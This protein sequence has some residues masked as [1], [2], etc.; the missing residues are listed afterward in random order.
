MTV[1]KMITLDDAFSGTVS[2]DN[3]VSEL[4]T[5]GKTW[6]SYAESLP[7]V[8]YTGG[9]VYP[10]LRRHNPLSYISDVMGTPQTV[11]LVPFTQFAAAAATDTANRVRSLGSS[12]T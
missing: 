4:L 6:K 8:G 10:Y 7:A 9:N 11:N 5:A 1:G 3:V 2:G 12:K